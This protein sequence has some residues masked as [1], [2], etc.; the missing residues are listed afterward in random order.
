MD[1]QGPDEILSHLPVH[2]R[3]TVERLLNTPE[4]LREIV[5]RQLL[6]PGA[7]KSLVRVIA[8]LNAQRVA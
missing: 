4:P 6:R 2:L 5:A 7:P 8:Q 1:A 3:P